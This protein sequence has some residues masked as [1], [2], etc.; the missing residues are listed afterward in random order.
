MDEAPVYPGRILRAE[1]AAG[2]DCALMAKECRGS[3]SFWQAPW[4]AALS[5]SPVQPF[6]TP[7]VSFISMNLDK[8]RES[9]VKL[10]GTPLGQDLAAAEAA[11]AYDISKVA[12]IAIFLEEGGSS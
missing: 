3:A 7:A 9:L 2:V 8:H 12:L 11:G 1:V 5:A 10:S 4:I 6:S